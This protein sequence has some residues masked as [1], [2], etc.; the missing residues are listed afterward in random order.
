MSQFIDILMLIGI[1]GIALAILYILQRRKVVSKAAARNFRNCFVFSAVVIIG[2]EILFL[3]LPGSWR[4]QA[5]TSIFLLGSVG[6]WASIATW[7]R[8]RRQAGLLLL[9]I[10]LSKHPKKLLVAFGLIVIA[11]IVPL[12][13]PVS[14]IKI[15]EFSFSILFLSFA[16]YILFVGLNQVEIR[17]G[18]ILLSGR[19]IKWQQIEFYE[20]EGENGLT[21]TL[22]LRQR[23]TFFRTLSLPIR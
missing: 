8:R 6:I 4:E 18:G 23:F 16:I 20:W 1:T 11:G 19:F 22:R 2:W 13:K 14:E 15:G 10:S 21:L 12:F 9:D 17:E 7:P 3:L 5:L